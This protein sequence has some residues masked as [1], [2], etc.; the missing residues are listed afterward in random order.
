MVATLAPKDKYVARE[1]ASAPCMAPSISSFSMQQDAAKIKIIAVEN[2][3]FLQRF[4]IS[5]DISPLFSMS[6]W[7]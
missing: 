7:L 6:F 1:D 5:N 3:L 4:L 2:S